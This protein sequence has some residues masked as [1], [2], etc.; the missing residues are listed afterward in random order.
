MYS[1]NQ[2]PLKE[3]TALQYLILIRAK[4]KRNFKGQNNLAICYL[5]EG[6]QLGIISV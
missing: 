3:K 6:L 1:K 4:T 5:L 2:S